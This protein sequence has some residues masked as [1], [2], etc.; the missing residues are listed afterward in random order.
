MYL[1][2]QKTLKKV[3]LEFQDELDTDGAFCMR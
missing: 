3:F 2:A 1:D